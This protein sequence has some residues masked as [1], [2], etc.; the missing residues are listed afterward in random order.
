MTIQDKIEAFKIL[1]LNEGTSI[2]Q[3]TSG[4]TGMPKEIF[5][6]KTMMTKSAQRTIDFFKLSENQKALICI[7]PE[8]IGGKMMIIRSLIAK[9]KLLATEP[10]N[11]LAEFLDKGIEIDFAAMVPSQLYKNYNHPNF[12]KIKNLIIGGAA[13]RN[14]FIPKLNDIDTNIYACY[15]MTET[16]SHIALRKLNHITQEDYTILNGISIE[17][18]PRNCLVIR[19]ESFD[20]KKI[21]TTDLVEIIT[22]KTFKLKGR[23]DNVIN[24]G[25]IKINPVEV[26]NRIAKELGVRGIISS[27]KDP[28]WGESVVFIVQED[29][30]LP[31]DFLSKSCT[32]LDKA[33]SPRRIIRLKKIPLSSNGKLLRTEIRKLINEN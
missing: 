12:S 7:S 2:K 24:S 14:D 4:S 21:V 1:W 33:S 8:Y 22:S 28:K 15:G 31:I 32:F 19:S 16:S 11:D 26:E 23:I 5:L 27:Q 9:M 18:D 20:E 3:L 25:G 29:E 13:I 17:S 6:S 10:K 30:K